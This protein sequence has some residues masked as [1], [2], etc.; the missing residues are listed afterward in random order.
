VVE[1]TV[2]L[3]GAPGATANTT[4]S[5]AGGK[6]LYGVTG[7]V[8]GTSTATTA[9]GALQSA[10]PTTA[11]APTAGTAAAVVTGSVGTFT[12]TLTAIGF[13]GAP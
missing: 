6:V 7:E 11:V 1:A 8:S 3:V 9:Q 5:C 10:F 13:C 12:G 4:V 2:P